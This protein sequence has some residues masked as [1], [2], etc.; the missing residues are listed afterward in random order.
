M[1]KLIFYCGYFV[2]KQNGHFY[3][4]KD[5]ETK[6]K[7]VDY[8]YSEIEKGIYSEAMSYFNDK[9]RQAQIES[10]QIPADKILEILKIMKECDSQKMDDAYDQKINNVIGWISKDYENIIKTII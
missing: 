4:Q 7:Q 5:A 1:G 3:I 10:R 9:I 2:I 6:P 8:S